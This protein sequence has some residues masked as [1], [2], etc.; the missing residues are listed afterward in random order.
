MITA[1]S[2]NANAQTLVWPADGVSISN[3]TTD[4]RL[5]RIVSDGAGGAI[6]VWM[7]NGM[8]WDLYVQRVDANGQ[9]PWG[10]RGILIDSD[11]VRPMYPQLI[12]DG[13]GGAIITWGRGLIHAQR[14]DPNGNLLWGPNGI[15]L[16]NISGEAPQIA[17]DGFGNWVIVWEDTEGTWID[18]YMQKIDINGNLEWAAE[19]VALTTI[20]NGVQ[21][22]RTNSQSYENARFIVPDGEG[23]VIITWT[24]RV[25]Y[26]IHAQRVDA[27]GNALWQQN[28]VVVCGEEGWQTN[29]SIVSDGSGGAIITWADGRR[30]STGYFS[31]RIDDIYAQRIDIDGQL[32]WTPGGVPICTASDLSKWYPMIESDGAGGAIIV[33]LD[34]R[35]G[36]TNDWGATDLYAQRV[37]PN[38]NALWAYNGIALS[39]QPYYQGDVAIVKQG[40]ND[41]IITWLDAQQADFQSYHIYAQK[42]DVN[43]N[44]Q[45]AP[46]GEPI[47][48]VDSFK[49]WL[50]MIQDSMGR[51]ILSWY[52][53]RAGYNNIYA[54]RVTIEDGVVDTDGDGISDE[55]D[56][57]PDN[58]NPDQDDVDADGAGDVCDVCPD[59]A[60]DTCDADAS[61][62]ENIAS[63]EGGTIETPDGS[64]TINIPPGALDNDTTISITEKSPL[65]ANV[66][67]G[68][69]QGWIGEQFSFTPNGAVFNQPVTIIVE[70]N[71]TFFCDLMTMWVYNSQTQEWEDLPTTCTNIGGTAY[72]C[73]A[74][75]THFTLFAL[76]NPLD[77]DEDG[78]TDNWYGEVDYCPDTIIPENIPEK[79]LIVKHFADIDGDGIFETRKKSFKPITDSKYTLKDTC[80]CSCEQI[81]DLKP[82]LNKGEKYFGCS[83]G[84]MWK[85]INNKGWAR[86][87]FE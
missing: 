74:E 31:T 61:A 52:D 14:V 39:T 72:S 38:G 32:L 24:N 81:L 77:S 85:F 8:N 69:L 54:Q 63:D 68:L 82:G 42:M 79:K 50:G 87:S 15:A 19:G 18:L 47:C 13:L 78:I 66:R 16:G 29:P 58:V 28:G 83:K 25:G 41:F 57:C 12:S 56:N 9:L 10:T 46:N 84:T 60:T 55:S 73:A 20:N 49:L 27:N 65:E 43:G 48:T 4:Q 30:S 76:V 80:G 3:A 6:I 67:M 53:N 86:V 1:L 51:V 62:S 36:S 40:P 45:W 26:N 37:A 71:C 11:A 5:P 23:G 17:N 64:A 70:T 44:I 7:E 75:T 21:S 33:W 34:M 2:L 35:S 22:I 59:D